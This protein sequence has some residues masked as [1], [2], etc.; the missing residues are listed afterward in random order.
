[1]I[2]LK[3]C[4]ICESPDVSQYRQFGAAPRVKYE[5][6]PNVKVSAAILT[7]Y[8]ICKKCH[9]IFQN[10]RMSKRELEEYYKKGYYRRMINSPSKIIDEDEMHRAKFDSKIIKEVI[11]KVESHL[12]VGASRG[13][14]LEKVGAE[15][16]VGIEP[17]IESIKNK[18]ITAY[19]K[20]GKVPKRKF[21]LVSAI[22]TL[23][24]LPDPLKSL[25]EMVKF[26]EKDGY[27]VIEVPTWKSPGG[28]LRLSHLFHFEPDVMRFICKEV[29]LE[30]VETKFTPHLL[31]VCKLASN[32]N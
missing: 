17:N 9:V 24:H 26:V 1:M 15:L 31:V 12:D 7:S 10:P 28:P 19:A 21:A 16:K 25:R 18:E 3:N 4:P 5:I 13:F 2:K 27:V 8:F 32:D 11:G 20:I 23:E 14:F 30:I 22:H 29:G 6:M